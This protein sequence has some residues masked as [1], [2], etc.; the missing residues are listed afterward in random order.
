MV[1]PEE[2]EPAR[3]ERANQQVADK[4]PAGRMGKHVQRRVREEEALVAARV[5]GAAVAKA[6]VKV[7]ALVAVR[8]AVRDVVRIVDP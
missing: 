6:R 8:A 3:T 4:A 5:R 2:T 7:A 1:C